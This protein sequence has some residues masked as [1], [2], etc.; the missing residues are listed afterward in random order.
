MADV[1]IS[2]SRKDKGFVLALHEALEERDRDTWVDWEDIPL[3]ANWREEL[4]F[5]IEGADT[6]AFV[7]SPDSVV[8]E[9]CNQELDHAVENNK[10]LV[11]I[12]HRDVNHSSVPETLSSHQYVC[13]SES[14]DLAFESCPVCHSGL[15][16]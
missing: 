12:W 6:F 15:L 5:A 2:Y 3:T 13:F 8:S 9:Y 11:P 7:I 10:R 14:N 4:C 16:K 1:F